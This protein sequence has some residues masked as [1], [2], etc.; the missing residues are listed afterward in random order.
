MLSFLL[1]LAGTC[2]CESHSHCHGLVEPLIIIRMM[3]L[4]LTVAIVLLL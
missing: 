1:L 4:L 2:V 3:L